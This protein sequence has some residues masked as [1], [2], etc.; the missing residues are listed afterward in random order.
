MPGVNDSPEQVERIV[1]IA[2][3]AGAPRIGGLAL[4]L[5]GEVRDIFMDGLRANRPDLGWYYEELYRRSA[6]APRKVQERASR[7]A[8]LPGSPPRSR[9]FLRDREETGHERAAA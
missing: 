2:A 7:L 8:R 3:E 9:R 4:P 5:R 1:E 6:Y